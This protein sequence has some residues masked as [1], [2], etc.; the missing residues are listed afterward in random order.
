MLT[1]IQN[2]NAFLTVDANDDGM[3]N[4]EFPLR[5]PFA[6]C[7]SFRTY[8]AVYNDFLNI[9]RNDDA[10]LNAN[11]FRRTNHIDFFIIRVLCDFEDF[12][13]SRE[14]KE[15]QKSKHYSIQSSL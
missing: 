9:E 4:T 14:F 1:Y 13:Q 15:V 11:S 2:D 12:R 6:I 10:M 8:I 3:L 5:T 7:I